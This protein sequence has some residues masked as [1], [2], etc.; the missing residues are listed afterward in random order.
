MNPTQ[1]ITIIS[2]SI[3]TICLIVLTYWIASVLSSLKQ[4]VLKTNQVIDNAK[5]I[6]DN[7]NAPVT[8]IKDFFVGI[9]EG[10]NLVSSFFNKKNEF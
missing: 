9:R 8:Q 3:L 2:I 1:L 7:I 5:L 6:T 10:I 4:T